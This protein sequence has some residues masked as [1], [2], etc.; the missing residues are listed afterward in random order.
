M[1]CAYELTYTAFRACE[2]AT[3]WPLFRPVIREVVL[4]TLW[5][6]FA[7][8]APGRGCTCKPG[9]MYHVVSRAG[10]RLVREPVGHNRKEAERRLRAIEVEIDQDRVLARLKT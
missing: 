6:T 10:G 7:A 8:A 9:P 4:W 1:A 5:T 2:G 3:S